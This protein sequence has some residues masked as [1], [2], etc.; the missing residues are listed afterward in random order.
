MQENKLI[1]DLDSFTTLFS[2]YDEASKLV[3]IDKD[4]STSE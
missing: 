4:Q 3:K 2:L 1:G